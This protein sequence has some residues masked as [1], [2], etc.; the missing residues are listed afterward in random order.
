LKE[1]SYWLITGEKL[2]PSKQEISK[3]PLK[4]L[5]TEE[6]FEE[7]FISESIKSLQMFGY[8]DWISINTDKIDFDACGKLFLKDLKPVIESHYSNKK[9]KAG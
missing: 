6:E 1:F 7:A 2:E 5:T 4:M 3:Q 8:L 9:K